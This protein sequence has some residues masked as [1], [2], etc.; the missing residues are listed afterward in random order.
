MRIAGLRFE[1]WTRNLPNTKQELNHPTTTFRHIFLRFTNVLMTN[2]TSFELSF[3]F[4]NPL[5]ALYDH[6]FGIWRV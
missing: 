2:C 4:E 6:N 1:I 3:V 5:Q